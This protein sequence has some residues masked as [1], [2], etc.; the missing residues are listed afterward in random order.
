MSLTVSSSCRDGCEV[1]TLEGAV[2]DDVLAMALAA[3]RE[4]RRRRVIIDINGL[5]LC[6]RAPF[7]S[8]MDMAT[9]DERAEVAVVCRRRSARRLLERWGVAD[10]V[11]VYDSLDAV[12]ARAAGR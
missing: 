7:E 12:L 8:L 9:D 10:V 6:T 2:E 4:T 1:V 11:A 3:L 5:T